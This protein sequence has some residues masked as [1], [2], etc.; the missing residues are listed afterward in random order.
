MSTEQKPSQ[1]QSVVITGDV[2]VD[3]YI[4]EG[5]RDTSYKENVRGVREVIELGGANCIHKILNKLMEKAEKDEAENYKKE[6]PDA[7]FN[8][9]ENWMIYNDFSVANKGRNTWQTSY[10]LWKPYVLKNDKFVFRVSKELGYGDQQPVID[11]EKFISAIGVSMKDKQSPNIL[12]IDDAGVQFRLKSNEKNWLLNKKADW[13]VYKMSRPLACGDLW[14]ELLKTHS[15]NLIVIVS[16][17]NLRAEDIKIT[18]GSSWE[19]TVEDIRNVLLSTRNVSNLAKG[20]HLIINFNNDGALWIDNTNRHMPSAKLLCDTA[21][22]EYEWSE[23]IQGTAFGYMSCLTAAIVYSMIHKSEKPETLDFVTGIES[24]LSAMRNLLENG[25]GYVDPNNSQLGF[26]AERIA[27]EIRKPSHTLAVIS[28]PWVKS[29]ISKTSGQWMIAEMLQRSPSLKGEVSLNGLANLVILYGV[30]ILDNIPFAKFKSLTTI[31]RTE[32]ETL[33]NIKH[34]MIEYRDNPKANKPISFGVFGP[35][36]AGKSF[37]VKQIA[38]EVFEEKSWLEFNLSQFTVGSLAE[39]YGAF[40]QIRDKVLAGIIPV[41]FM[42]EFDS[43]KY[44]WLQYL[45][46]PMQD[47]EF[48]EGQLKHTI[49]KC[50][51]IFAGATSYTFDSFGYFNHDAEGK[52][53]LKDF[54]L[55]KGPDFKSRLDAY[56]NVLGPNQRTLIHKL[57]EVDPTDISF[58]LRRAIFIASKI[59][60]QSY[61]PAPIDLG[62]IN[63]L[64][65]IS[66]YIHGARSL[67]KLISI[68]KTADGSKLTRS[69][70][71]SDTQLAMYVDPIEFNKLLFEPLT[72]VKEIPIEELAKAIHFAWQVKAN[73]NKEALT[74]EFDKLFMQLDEEGKEDN[75]AAARRIQDILAIVNLKIEKVGIGPKL[76]PI[77]HKEI[78]NHILHHIESLSA[79]E[80]NGWWMQRLKAGWEF[81]EIRDNKRKLHH[82][83]KPYSELPNFEKE[84]DRNSIRNYPGMLEKVGYQINWIN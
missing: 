24:G 11:L 10:S 23:K 45:L 56:I 43:K 50:I 17:D 61:L 60:Y 84:K 33:R 15:D 69:N 82:L 13:I 7:K 80:H 73:E 44:E 55:K 9:T 37:G 49:G 39:L 27:D 25:H 46:S 53:A 5:R 31:D 75:R 34:L 32:I 2:T 28:I 62:L 19:Q 35:P 57:N 66:K 38:Y 4:Y 76:D 64:L 54:I 14:E 29:N 20:R 78:L 52:N 42:D 21:R 26:P 51:F 41:V 63:A 6:R 83:L 18:K 79:L 65:R 67:D 47:G 59:K 72:N 8:I 81:A 74:E 16:A 40:H 68:L 36:G 71:P 58:P 48:Q 30:K 3:N 70:I 1:L 77:Q 22:A 12:V